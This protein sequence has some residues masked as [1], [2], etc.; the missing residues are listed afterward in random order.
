MLWENAETVAATFDRDDIVK[1][2]ARVESY[3]NKLQLAVDK[4]RPRRCPAKSIWRTIFPH[5]A[6]DVEKLY[7]RLWSTSPR[8]QIP[9]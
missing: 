8:S 7:A 3:R 1:V 9:G 5:T 4:L 6:E 2:Q